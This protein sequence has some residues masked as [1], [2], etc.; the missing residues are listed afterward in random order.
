MNNRTKR[1]DLSDWVI[2]FVHNRKWEDDLYVLR[3]INEME[4]DTEF[5]ITT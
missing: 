4:S 1:R 3:D 2:H 5:R